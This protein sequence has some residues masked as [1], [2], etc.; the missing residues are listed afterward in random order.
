MKDFDADGLLCSWGIHL[1][2][3]QITLVS[4]DVADLKLVVNICPKCKCPRK[5]TLKLLFGKGNYRIS[6][7]L[8]QEL[9]LFLK[10]VV[11]GESYG[12]NAFCYRSRTAKDLQLALQGEQKEKM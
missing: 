12:E 10:N 2:N 6:K 1:H 8:F 4:P 9:L 11:S 7:E 3:K 5:K